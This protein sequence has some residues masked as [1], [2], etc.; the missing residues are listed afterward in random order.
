MLFHRYRREANDR[1]RHHPRSQ[2]CYPDSGQSDGPGCPWA[3]CH[4]P[5]AGSSCGPG[6]APAAGAGGHPERQTCRAHQ[7]HRWQRLWWVCSALL[8]GTAPQALQPGFKA[9]S[10]FSSCFLCIKLFHVSISKPSII[11]CLH[12][13]SLPFLGL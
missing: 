3:D 1:L 11:P 10:V 2:P 12:L 6:A 4:H 7:Q 5:A 9:P 8:A 13:A